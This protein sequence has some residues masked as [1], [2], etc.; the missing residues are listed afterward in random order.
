MTQQNAQ[1]QVFDSL[2]EF[3]K[4]QLYQE[5]SEE[6]QEQLK[7]YKGKNVVVLVFETPE[8]AIEFI[9]QIQQ[10]N[11]INKTQADTLIENLE[12]LNESQYKSG[13]R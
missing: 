8:Q 4:S 12:A 2:D 11:L 6:E 9:Q 5:I 1:P 10:K 3:K 13:M 7:Q